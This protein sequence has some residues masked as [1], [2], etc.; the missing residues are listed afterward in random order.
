MSVRFRFDWVEAPPSPDERARTTMATLSIRVGN[1]TVTDVLDR[2]SRTNRDHVV[3]PLYGVAEW[4][5]CNWWHIFHEIEDTTEQKPDFVARHD[6]AFVGDG[7]VLPRL[8]MVPTPERMRLQWGPRKPPHA[9]IEFVAE[10]GEAD[11]AHA[12]LEGQ[13]RGLIE[14]VLERLRGHGLN[15]GVLADEW[16]AINTLDPDER[17]FSRAAALLGVDPFDVSDSLAGAIAELWE[18]SDPALRGDALAAASVDSV[19]RMSA[20]LTCSLT[21]LERAGDSGDWPAIRQALPQGA[22]A[23]PWERGYDLARATRDRIGASDGRFDFPSTGPL[24]VYRSATQP[25]S[26]RIHGLTAVD[27]P[28]C[29]TVPRN[30]TGER[31]LLARTL[32]DYMDRSEPGAALLSSLA[33]SR[34]ARSRAFAAEFLAPAESLRRRLNGGPVE[35][36]TVDELGAEFGVSSMVIC[37]QIENHELATVADW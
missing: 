17:E 23:V 20:W 32:G 22:A 18:G 26:A 10:A 28:A 5:I 33:T 12:D 6:L 34:Q 13:C 4:L 35:P 9:L 11:V 36:E 16:T 3:V 19:S 21:A 7:F 25:P 14:A 30:E 31:F 1:A 27:A 8:S 29:V 24:S 15:P 37:R 2:P